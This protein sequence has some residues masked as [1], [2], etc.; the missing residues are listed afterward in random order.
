MTLLQINSNSMMNKFGKE[1][2]EFLN[3]K[4]ISIKE[5]AGRLNT[6]SKNLI[7]IIKGNVEL[8]QNMI[9]NI[10]FITDIPV[11]YIENVEKNYRMDKTIKLYLEENHLTIRNYINKFNYKELADKYHV[12]YRDSRNDYS[13]AK[14]ILKYLR[15]TNPNTLTKE[16]N[17]IFYK[18]KNDKPE[19]LALWLE[20]CNRIIES[21]KIKEYN[22]E[23]I[24]ILVKFIKEEASNC[25]FNEDKLIKEFNKYGIFL[26]IE[27]DLKGTKVRGAFKV[28]NDK[29]AIFL[30]KKH[31]R[32]ADIY[33]AL[34]HEL[35]HCKSDFNRAK[36]GSII[37]LAD[38]KETE[39][40]E[41][42]ADQQA[43][44]WM[45]NDELYDSIKINYNNIENYNVVKSFFV[46]RLAKDNIISY[47]NKLYQKYNPIIN[48][49]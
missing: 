20:R 4:N 45:I 34:L 9:Y 18:S 49:N 2:G 24:N 14:D 26:A 46:Y 23:N 16:N 11:N 7:D 21:Q 40:Y 25:N 42:K 15:I 22:K 27:D 38:E 41:I 3:Y 19:L 47:S 37:T 28:L 13:I 30:T 32:Y 31:K 36:R 33:F 39:D 48:N 29:P 43:L 5:F 8:S 12:V 6:T 1:L 44:N 35:A 10:S 17:V